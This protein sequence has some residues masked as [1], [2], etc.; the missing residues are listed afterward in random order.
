[1]FESSLTECSGSLTE[2]TLKPRRSRLWWIVLSGVTLLLVGLA[3]GVLDPTPLPVSTPVWNTSTA[4][5]VPTATMVSTL[6]PSP[7]AEMVPTPPE[8]V[9]RGSIQLG[10]TVQGTLPF[11]G[12]DVWVFDAPAGQYVTIRMDAVDPSVLDTYLE[13]YDDAGVLV[14]ED[15]DGGGDGNSLIVGF[16]IVVTGTYTIHALTYSGAGDYV[17]GV[18][19]VEPSGGGTLWY[20]AT[21]EGVLPAPW[22]RHE[23]TFEGEEGQVV[24]VA[25]DAADG[26]LDCY[27]ELYGPDGVFLTDDDDSGVE[28]GALIEYYALP[29]EGTYRVVARGGAFGATGAYVLTLTQTEMVV[30][31]TLAYSDTV[32]ATL[33]PGTRHHWLFEGQEGDV[34]SISMAAVG[35]DM[36]TYLELFAPDGVRVATDDDGGGGSNATIVVFELPLSG[37]YRIIA[38]GHSDE[39]VGEYE[40]ALT[41][42]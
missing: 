37:T 9:D 24:N 20:T 11:L 7:T 28:Y 35:G 38:R 13:L 41:G 30:Q 26:V 8:P 5:S 2:R 16:P 36:D 33:E 32:Q 1:M 14:A 3:C 21:V 27:L 12:T 25:M 39:D 23:W 31:S 17:L 15:D 22:S 6:S 42:P 10:E 4:L 40:L 29:V 34:V 18:D 19:I